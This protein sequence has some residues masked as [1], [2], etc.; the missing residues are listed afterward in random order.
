MTQCLAGPPQFGRVTVFFFCS[1]QGKVLGICGNVGSGKSSLIAA[2]LGQ[3][4]CVLSTAEMDPNGKGGGSLPAVFEV[5][6]TGS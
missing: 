4:R 3:V 6:G 5:P 1:S 2:L